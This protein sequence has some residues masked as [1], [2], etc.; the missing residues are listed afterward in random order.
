[1][2]CFDFGGS[3]DWTAVSA[4]ATL[5]MT[6]ATFITIIYSRKQMKEIQR[7]WEEKNKARLAFSI[8]SES[9]LFMLKIEN[10]GNRTAYDVH[11]NIDDEF[12]DKMLIADFANQ[13]K[14]L[15]EKKMVLRPGR[16]LYYAISPIQS[17]KA[18]THTT[19]NGSYSHSEVND[20]LNIIFKE[21]IIIKGSYNEH[22]K[23][24]ECFSIDDFV[25]S[26]IV[27][28]QTEKGLKEISKQVKELSKTL[29]SVN[30]N[31]KS[32]TSRK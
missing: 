8:I 27:Y 32:L 1:M 9:G 3:I 25:G 24:N 22:E 23:I 19:Q 20:N 2:I 31:L 28:S 13:L 29:L 7:Q 16:I 15:S 21:P 10:A 12:I 14:G 26:I 4:I 18:N 11:I 6:I 30:D 5:L 17:D